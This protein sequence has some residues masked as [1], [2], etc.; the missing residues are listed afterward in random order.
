VKAGNERKSISYPVGLAGRQSDGPGAAQSGCP[1]ANIE[2][3]LTKESLMF[4]IHRI[5]IQGYVGCNR[6]LVLSGSL[7]QFPLESG[8]LSGQLRVNGIPQQ[9]F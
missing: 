2:G 6:G 3:G 9:P 8:F 5:T 4:I 7:S 1:C